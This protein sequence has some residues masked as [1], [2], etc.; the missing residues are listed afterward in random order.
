MARWFLHLTSSASQNQNL[1][2]ITLGK[3]ATRAARHKYS[4]REAAVSCST[5]RFSS[6]LWRWKDFY[7]YLMMP[8]HR[9]VL[10]QWA[11]RLIANLCHNFS[12]NSCIS[13]AH[14]SRPLTYFGEV[15]VC[16][17]AGGGITGLFA[18]QLILT[19]PSA[20]RLQQIDVEISRLPKEKQVLARKAWLGCAMI[21]KSPEML[22]CLKK[23]A[24]TTQNQRH[25]LN[26]RLCRLGLNI[27]INADVKHLPFCGLDI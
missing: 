27:Q 25:F 3:E 16:P 9:G 12:R 14:P 21:V 2:L 6:S 13:A 7:L 4:P 26:L 23:L 10:V 20:N 17:G 22:A 18:A 19:V 24:K 15:Q 5:F 1:S 11:Q 8:S